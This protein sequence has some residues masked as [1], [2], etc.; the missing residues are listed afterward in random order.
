MPVTRST[1]APIPNRT[2][3]AHTHVYGRVSAG[4]VV[5]RYPTN[6]LAAGKPGQDEKVQV[7]GVKHESPKPLAAMEWLVRLVTIPGGLVLDPFA[8]SGSALLKRR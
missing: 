5:G 3:A 7:D 8:D 6:V 1:G 2:Y 4:T